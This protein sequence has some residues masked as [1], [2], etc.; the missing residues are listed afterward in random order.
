M[1]N[2]D[3]YPA[4][5]SRCLTA[6]ANAVCPPVFGEGSLSPRLVLIGEAPGD[7]ETRQG[8]P[9]V[10]KAGQNLNAF[11]EVLELKRE[12]IY[13]TNMVKV[14]PTK[15]KTGSARLSNRPPTPAEVKMHRPF[16]LEEIAL[17]APEILVTLGN[18]PLQGLLGDKKITVGEV[19]GT[20]LPLKLGEQEYRLFALYHPASIIY[21]RSLGEVYARD[22]QLLSQLI[23][24]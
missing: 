9:F 19:H 2:T 5:K 11:L 8:R 21:N 7:Q 12:D 18:T 23:K 4:L 16:L 22:L 14:R 13:I 6:F 3:A 15:C 24:G 17:L 10:G 20:V 1:N